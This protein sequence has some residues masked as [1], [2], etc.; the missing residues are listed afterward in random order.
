MGVTVDYPA[1]RTTEHRILIVDDEEVVRDSLCK[2]FKGAGYFVESAAGSRKALEA[3]QEKDFDIALIDI[4]M[5]G[6]DGMELQDRLREA[7]PELAVI[8]MTGYASVETAVRAM[9]QGAYEFITKPID[10]DELSRLVVNVLERTSRR[11]RERHG[12]QV[13]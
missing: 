10:P 7:D 4:K 12:D 5:P 2:W 3:I 8:I 6:M 11:I 1:R 13:P 9:K